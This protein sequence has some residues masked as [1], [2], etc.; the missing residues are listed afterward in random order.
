MRNIPEDIMHEARQIGASS[1]RGN[2]WEHMRKLFLEGMYD[3]HPVVASAADALMAER[4]KW[5]PK[6][7]AA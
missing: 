6:G 2:Q 1:Y 5:A 3:N 4:Q 7:D